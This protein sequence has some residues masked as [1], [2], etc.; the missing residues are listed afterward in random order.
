M[1]RQHGQ[2]SIV[3]GTGHTAGRVFAGKQPAVQVPGIAISHLTGTPKLS[4]SGA[5]V[6]PVHCIADD[7]TEQQTGVLAVPEGPFRE[8]ETASDLFDGR[9]NGER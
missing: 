8:D 1:T 5:S 4:K 3:L 9:I 6:P 7:V 2:R